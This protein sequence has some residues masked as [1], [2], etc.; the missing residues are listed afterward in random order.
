MNG[1]FLLTEF[2]YVVQY[3]VRE[4]CMLDV[5]K[6]ND[7]FTM[8]RDLRSGDLVATGE[9]PIE[10]DTAYYEAFF[11]SCE[12]IVSSQLK[13]PHLSFGGTYKMCEAEAGDLGISPQKLL[14]IQVLIPN[15]LY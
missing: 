12:S 10:A 3:L 8:C 15:W 13:S 5:L 6:S 7:N 2:L 9:K 14:H 11:K 4:M 1:A